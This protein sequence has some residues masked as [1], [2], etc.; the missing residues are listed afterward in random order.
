MPQI[1]CIYVKI[2]FPG[3]R[4]WTRVGKND[5]EHSLIDMTHKLRIVVL[6]VL[7]GL[8]LLFAADQL[9]GLLGFPSDVV[10]KSGHRANVSKTLKSIEFEYDFSTNTFGLRYPEIPLNKPPGETRILLLGDSFTEGV[11]VQASETFGNNLEDRYST[12][13][14]VPVRFVNAGLGGFGPVEF[15]RVFRA[16]GLKLHPDAVLICIYANDLM[17]TDESLSHEDLYNRRPTRQGVDKLAHSIF[18][19]LYMIVSEA[20]RI[21]ARELR[22]HRGFV[23]TVTAIARE[24][25]IDE[26]AI[27]RWKE[28][29][30]REL[31]EASD[32]KEFNRALLSMGLFNPQYWVEALEINTPR[33]ERKF[34]AMSLILDEITSVARESELAIGLVYI[35]APLQYDRSRHDSWNPWII[36]GAEVRE[37]W[38]EVDSE[39][40]KRLANWAQRNS[41]PF[42][43][44]TSELRAEVSRGRRLNFRLDGHWNPD[45]HLVAA[46]AIAEWIDSH[47]VFP[48]L[49]GERLGD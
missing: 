22:Q 17:D 20:R 2:S 21:G 15:W 28:N 30:P 42:L 25:G 43:D 19:R 37:E 11:G 27:Q 4:T 36:G 14:G 35:P 24:N 31:V 23:A 5:T 18:P 12:E 1:K 33:A 9:L 44:L 41:I 6:N 39:I 49:I 29:L 46:D 3:A 13:L 7:V 16:A 38:V 45:G 48:G 47:N 26:D 34:Q 10:A 8:V 32:R 40:Q